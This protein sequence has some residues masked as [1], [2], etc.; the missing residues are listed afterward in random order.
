MVALTLNLISHMHKALAQTTC[1]AYLNETW[2]QG[3]QFMIN[4][5]IKNLKNFEW[6]HWCGS[7]TLWEWTGMKTKVPEYSHTH[8]WVKRCTELLID[9]H[10]VVC[11]IRWWGKLEVR[12][13]KPKHAAGVWWEVLELFTLTSER[14][15]H[16][17]W[18]KVRGMKPKYTVF[19]KFE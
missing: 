4:I 12:P 2:L 14:P 15:S 5:N 8:F 13:S 6:E 17:S 16:T 11:W 1:E 18:K 7:L 9:H 10:V 3:V 19:K